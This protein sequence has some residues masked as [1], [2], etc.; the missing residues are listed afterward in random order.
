M[1]TRFFITTINFVLL[2]ENITWIGQLRNLQTKRT[3]I[4]VE[5]VELDYII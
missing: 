1:K 3:I 4:S 5:S 2:I